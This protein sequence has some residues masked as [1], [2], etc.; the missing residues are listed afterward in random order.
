MVVRVHRVLALVILLFA[1]ELFL[2]WML[3]VVVRG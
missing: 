2:M 3:Y 1:C